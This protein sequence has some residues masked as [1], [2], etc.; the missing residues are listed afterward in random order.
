MSMTTMFIIFT[1]KGQ[2]IGHAEGFVASTAEGIVVDADIPEVGA[3]S[4]LTASVS[5]A[6]FETIVMARCYRT[7]EAG[8]V[9]F[10][11]IESYLDVFTPENGIIVP[12]LDG[13][14]TGSITWHIKDGGGRFAGASGIVTGN[15]VGY[16]DGTFIDHQ[17]YRII[18]P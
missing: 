12:S 1:G 11:E 16:P 10:P 13:R 3:D 5:T 2:Q 17:V 4:R 9:T 6:R 18:L 14:E 15:F 7:I 8:R